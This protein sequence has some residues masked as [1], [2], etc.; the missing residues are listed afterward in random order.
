MG[1][2][3]EGWK[4]VWR[5]PG[6]SV[7]RDWYEGASAYAR[8]TVAGERLLVPAGTSDPGAAHGAAARVY[9][10]VIARG[11]RTTRSVTAS[12]APLP[13][14]FATWLETL[15]QPGVLDPATAR[16]YRRDYVRPIF[17]VE[18]ATLTEVADEGR[19]LAM[20]TRLLG[21]M[22]RSSVRKALSA[23]RGF[24]RWAK[25][26]GLLG[27]M[28]EWVGKKSRELLPP[29]AMGVRTGPQRQTAP[30]YSPTEIE[31]ALR[32][33]PELS[34]RGKANPRGKV[35]PKFI[36]RARFVLAYETAL[37]PATLDKLTWEDWDGAA[38]LTI[39]DEAD[40]ARFGRELP[41]SAR[42]QG[43]LVQARAIARAA[44]GGDALAERLVFGRHDY[45]SQLAK[46]AKAAGIESLADYDFRH[47][48]LTHWGDERQPVTAMAYLAGHT[49]I[50]T[51]AKYARGTL[52]AAQA[53]VRTE[54]SG[55]E[56]DLTGTDAVRRRGLE[57]LQVLPRQNLNQEAHLRRLAN[58]AAGASL[59]L[60]SLPHGTPGICWAHG[61]SGSRSTTLAG[62]TS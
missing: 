6:G 9:A 10:D 62:V 21:R 29:K 32:A 57:P 18:F 25:H 54:D 24:V 17:L 3:A 27:V 43:A 23:L 2:R 15:E 60:P 55:S 45:R 22:L 4:L 50:T 34:A 20:A 37:R 16:A 30:L 39:R 41:L 51:T 56:V 49:Q 13:D 26:A 58:L 1:R 59:G 35:G 53:V 52:R 38:R 61:H 44:D 31:A 14:M 28:P 12:A 42:A 48:R 11:L 36:V 5:A 19:V 7:R 47:A 8:F 33:L 46:A 40:K